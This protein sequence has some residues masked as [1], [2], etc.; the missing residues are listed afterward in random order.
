MIGQQTT[1]T[2]HNHFTALFPGPP[3]WAGARRE[4]LNF[5][6]HGKID[7]GRH[8][9]HP[10]GCH[11]IQTNQCPSPPGHQNA[12]IAADA[13]Q[14]RDVAMTIIFWLLVGYNY[15]CMVASDKMIDS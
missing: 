9:D 3:R 14:L 4:L 8:T 6:V 12:D 1:T 5:M 2:H 15:C 13:V 7:R 11:S 10:A